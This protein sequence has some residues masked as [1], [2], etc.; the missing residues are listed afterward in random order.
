MENYNW[1]E[2]FDKE[3]LIELLKEILPD[4]LCEI[5]ENSSYDDL[6]GHL[7]TIDNILHEWH[8]SALAI[9]LTEVQH[10]KF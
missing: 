7:S 1:L 9:Q 4:L 2:V 6:S 8:K 5:E 3:D 10:Y